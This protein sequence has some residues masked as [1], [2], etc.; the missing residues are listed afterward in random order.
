MM[1]TLVSAA[2]TETNRRV[3]DD[4]GTANLEARALN[5]ADKT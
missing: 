5:T 3:E 2:V 4:G 1:E